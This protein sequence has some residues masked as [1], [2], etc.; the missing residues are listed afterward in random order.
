MLTVPEAAKRLGRNPETVRRWIRAGK[1]TAWKV[2]TQH[3]IDEDDLADAVRGVF[4]NPAPGRDPAQVLAERKIVSALHQ[5]RAER[6]HQLREAGVPYLAAVSDRPAAITV[7][8]WL[9]AIVGRIVRLVDPAQIVLFGSRARGTAREDSD[10]DLLVV[11]DE[12]PARRET[13]LAIRRALA[14][15]G[16]ALDIVV[17]ASAELAA[18]RRGP[19]GIVQWAAEQGRVVYE[20]A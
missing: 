15:L 10:Y 2:G 17:A 12:L 9:P 1:L 16:L 4:T 6:M 13:R 7:D 19:R 3:V 18:D 5:S 20:R 8:P 14:D 11:V